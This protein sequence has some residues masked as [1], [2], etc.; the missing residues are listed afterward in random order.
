MKKD[1]AVVGLYAKV[2]SVKYPKPSS[3]K[4]YSQHICRDKLFTPRQTLNMRN[5]QFQH[6]L[7]RRDSHFIW[8]TVSIWSSQGGRGSRVGRGG[9]KTVE[10]SSQTGICR[11]LFLELSLI[12]GKHKWSRL[13]TSLLKRLCTITLKRKKGERRI[14]LEWDDMRSNKYM[15][16]LVCVLFFLPHI[17]KMEPESAQIDSIDTCFQLRC[18][19]YPRSR[20]QTNPR[21]N[22]PRLQIALGCRLWAKWFHHRT[23]AFQVWIYI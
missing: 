16:A 19:D 23:D 3:N 7:N 22:D 6:S 13:D 9:H 10:D 1:S 5:K 20:A 8:R 2:F 15:P 18:T 11:S 4:Y 21:L 14:E 12:S 17:R